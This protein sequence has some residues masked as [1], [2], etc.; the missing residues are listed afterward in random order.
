[1]ALRTVVV[2]SG[3]VMLLAAGNSA[4][5]TQYNEVGA[6]AGHDYLVVQGGLVAKGLFGKRASQ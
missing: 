4:A 2:G 1:M 3:L 5:F 6:A